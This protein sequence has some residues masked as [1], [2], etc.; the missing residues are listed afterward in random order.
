MAE[1]NAKMYERANLC[2]C[3]NCDNI[4]VD[5]NSQVGAKEYIIDLKKVTDLSYL[6]DKE[7]KDEIDG[8]EYFWGCGIC[9]TD[10]Y[11]K[12][13]IDEVKARKLEII[14]E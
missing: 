14:I 12:D 5:Q 6:K 13:D 10:A 9:E 1:S 7:P 11:L 3:N 4:F 8:G 2:Q